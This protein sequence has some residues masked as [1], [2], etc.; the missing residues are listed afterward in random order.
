MQVVDVVGVHDGLV[1]TT[2]AVGVTVSFGLV[3]NDRGHE[4]VPSAVSFLLNGLI[5]IRASQL[6]SVTIKPMG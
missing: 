6:G 1:P 2:G 3:V 5:R 4:L